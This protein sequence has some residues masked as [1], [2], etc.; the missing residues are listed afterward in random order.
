[1]FPESGARSFRDK[2]GGR[3]IIIIN[4]IL[5]IILPPVAAAPQV[6][7][8]THFW[9]NRAL[10]LLGGLPGMIHALWQVLT[11]YQ[12]PSAPAQAA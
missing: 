5:A 7:I 10:T 1:M 4:L 2:G 6:G 9:V 3:R 12:A 11:D 8:T